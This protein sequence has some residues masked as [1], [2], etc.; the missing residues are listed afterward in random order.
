MFIA[1]LWV[2]SSRPAPPYTHITQTGASPRGGSLIRS[3]NV[4]YLYALMLKLDFKATQRKFHVS[5][6]LSLVARAAPP[7]DAR[8][9]EGLI[10]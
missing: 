6:V 2:R 3:A 4:A 1:L 8:D 10:T 5:L 7:L 9:T